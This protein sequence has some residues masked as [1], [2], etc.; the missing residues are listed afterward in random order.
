M[1]I[2]L[3][4]LDTNVVLDLFV[5]DNPTA[6]PLRAMIRAGEMHCLSDEDCLD[7]LSRVLTYPKLNL[8]AAAQQSIHADYRACCT[9]LPSQRAEHISAI[10]P[11]CS[12]RDDQKFILLAVRGKADLLL[13]RDKAL[14]KM[15]KRMKAHAP[16]LSITTP[17]LKIVALQG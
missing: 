5:W 13:T 15:A 3:A 14:L 16:Q 4:V 2:P 12:D 7:E 6:E 9:V 17:S 11:R 8:D 1:T 10:L